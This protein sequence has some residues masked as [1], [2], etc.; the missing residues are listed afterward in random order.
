[1]NLVMNAPLSY[2]SIELGVTGPT[3]FLTEQEASGEAAIGWGGTLVGE[4]RADLC[5][6]GAT[7]ELDAV[8]HAV[9]REGG[10]LARREPRPYNPA[11]DGPC[12][13]EGAAVLLLEPMDHARARG[14]RIY[15]RLVP[16]PCFAVPSPVH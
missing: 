15:A 6:A 10:V 14:A 5:F 8:L 7:D 9:L 12:P 16:H 2:A 1:P 13:G 3:A 4:G 11:A